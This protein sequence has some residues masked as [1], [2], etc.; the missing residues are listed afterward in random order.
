MDYRPTGVE[1]AF[2]LAASGRVR[3]VSEVRAALR[4]EGYPEDG[5]LSGTT[6]SKQLAKLIAAAKPK[7]EQP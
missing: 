4:S 6:I 1:R 5:Q 7:A 3:S 2:I